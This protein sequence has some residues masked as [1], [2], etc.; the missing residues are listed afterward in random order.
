M[1]NKKVQLGVG[2]IIIDK[3]GKLLLCKRG[4]NARN[5]RGKWDLIGGGV[6]YGE[7]V[8][9]AAQREV[10]EEVNLDIQEVRKIGFFDH[11]LPDEHWVSMVLFTD[12][13]S[14]E[15][16]IME[17]DKIDD[18][19]WYKMDEIPINLTTSAVLAL[20]CYNEWLQANGGNS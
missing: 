3:K 15:L 4:E 13:F 1:D 18:I 17:H 8:I 16:K 20:D 2:V 6:E 5:E 19:G 10:K 7:P 9:K 11:M 14:G 12:S